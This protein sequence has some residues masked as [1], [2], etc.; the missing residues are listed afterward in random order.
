MDPIDY[1]AHNLPQIEY[2]ALEP[3]KAYSIN[4]KPCYDEFCMEFTECVSGDCHAITVDNEI[5]FNSY[6][7]KSIRDSIQDDMIRQNIINNPHGLFVNLFGKKKD[8]RVMVYMFGNKPWFL[9]VYFDASKEILR[10]EYYKSIAYKD[11]FENK[12]EYREVPK[13]LP[14]LSGEGNNLGY[15]HGARQLYSYGDCK[16]GSS[17]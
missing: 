11:S 17:H 16:F 1:S 5:L 3:S 7:P 13:M 14:S 4:S 12:T 15:I 9:G 6:E 10:V 2:D 8:A